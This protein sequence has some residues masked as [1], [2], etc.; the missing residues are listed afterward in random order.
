MRQAMKELRD[1]WI[2]WMLDKRPNLT[3]G[4]LIAGI[5]MSLASPAYSTY[6]VTIKDIV[7]INLMG[8]SGAF[9][10]VLGL[11]DFERSTK[12]SIFITLASCY[13]ILGAASWLYIQGN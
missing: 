13:F 7:A 6:F 10:L 1:G 8:W 3:V 2:V 12:R 5:I 11:R 4:V 9:F